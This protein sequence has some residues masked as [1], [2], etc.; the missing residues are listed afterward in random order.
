MTIVIC[1]LNGFFWALFD[2]TRKLSLKYISPKV[3]LTLF[4]IVQF[5]FFFSWVCFE[6]NFRIEKSYFIPG[7]ILVLISVI[8]AIIFLKSLV[9]SDLSLTIPLL[10]L[11]PIFSSFF[12]YLVLNETLKKIEYLGILIIVLG[13]L[14]LYAEKFEFRSIF[15]SFK[16][17][18]LNV[19]ARLMVLVSV[20]W[21]ITPIID[22]VCLNYT[23]VS[24]HG[25]IQSFGM[26][27]F[28]LIISRKEL[29]NLN[30]IN[31]NSGLIIITLCV[32]TIATVLQFYAILENYVA[33]MEAIK[34]TLGQTC[35]V[36][37]GFLIFKEKINLQKIVGVIILSAGVF[38]IL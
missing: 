20:F 11:T 36:L 25:F 19:G 14:I 7:L 26:L 31:K 18:S 9:L 10:S 5:I 22:K 3:L 2:V 21:S 6:E 27:L 23:S 13:T 8:S 38:F 37:F 24:L 16:R 34:R 28:L 35:A 32:G 30:K 17:I 1:I 33:I 29:T 15:K 12:S 4:M